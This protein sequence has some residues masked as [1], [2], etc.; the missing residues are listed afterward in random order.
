MLVIKTTF[1]ILDF[2]VS[3]KLHEWSTQ[4]LNTLDSRFVAVSREGGIMG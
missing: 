2:L 3:D 4:V 1:P